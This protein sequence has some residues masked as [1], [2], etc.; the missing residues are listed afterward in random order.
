MK[1]VK[2]FAVIGLVTLIGE[3]LNYLLPLPVPAS[4]YGMVLLF[5][6][7]KFRVIG[8]SQ[9]EETADWFLSVM[10]IFFIVPTVGIMDSYLLIKN[11]LLQ[12]VTLSVVSTVVVMVVT[13]W[14][15]QLIMRRDA[16]KKEEHK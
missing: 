1:Y 3:I 7:L 16:K 2:Q 8:L 12:I 9:V 15:S 11:E 6:C 13:G 5:L 10:P 4:I 14:V